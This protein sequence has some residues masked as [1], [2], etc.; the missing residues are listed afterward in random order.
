MRRMS[1]VKA[2]KKKRKSYKEHANTSNAIINDTKA[3]Y[4]REKL[5]QIQ[6]LPPSKSV[7]PSKSTTKTSK[8]EAVEFVT[9]SL[10]DSR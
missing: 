2:Q 5:R 7:S 9:Y 8:E 3:N 4:Q 10:T 6:G 1:E